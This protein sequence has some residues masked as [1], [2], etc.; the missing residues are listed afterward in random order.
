MVVTATLTSLAPTHDSPGSSYRCTCSETCSPVLALTVLH[1]VAWHA[2]PNTMVDDRPAVLQDIVQVGRL[3]ILQPKL[4]EMATCVT[5]NVPAHAWLFA[6]QG[7]EQAIVAWK[8]SVKSELGG[9]TLHSHHKLPCS[10]TAPGGHLRIPCCL[11]SHSWS[12]CCIRA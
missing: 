12:F 3:N 2:V 11:A 10:S 8:C 7:I 9:T 6:L 1:P 5:L 4:S